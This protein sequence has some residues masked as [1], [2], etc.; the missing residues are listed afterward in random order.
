MPE[1]F[2]ER[3]TQKSYFRTKL[4]LF[5]LFIFILN[6]IHAETAE[7]RNFFDSSICLREEMPESSLKRF[8]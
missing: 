2:L 4:Q 7:P 5:K 1:G 3:F 8:T 6:F